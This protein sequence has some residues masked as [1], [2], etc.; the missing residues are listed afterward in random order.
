[1]KRKHYLIAGLAG[2]VVLAGAQAGVTAMDAADA[3][4]DIEINSLA[5]LYEPVQFDH[6]MHVDATSGSCVTCHHHT[7][8]A[9]AEDPNCARCHRTAAE[10]DVVGCKDCHSAKRFEADYLKG[11]AENKALYHTEK[12]GLKGAYHLRCMGCHREMGAPVGCQDCHSRTDAGDK[13]FRAG[14][15]APAPGT[16]PAGSH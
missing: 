5:Q 2:L 6:A 16:K 11:V 10:S 7:T 12:V 4:A 1:M 15:Y 14:K 13:M 3:P 9:P 8:G